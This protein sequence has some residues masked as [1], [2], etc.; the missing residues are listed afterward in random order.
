[1][2]QLIPTLQV[3]VVGLM[4]AFRLE[5]GAMFQ[6]MVGAWIACLGRRSIS[7]VWETTGQAETR[8]HTSAFRLFSQAAWNWDD[9][10]RLLLLQILATL[11]PGVRV[12]LVVDDTLC[13]KRGAKVAFGGIFLDAVLSTKRHKV[14]RFGNNWVMLGVVVE[15]PFRP[16]RYFCLPILWRVYE[17]RGTKTKKEHRTKS[18][19]A[20]EMVSRVAQWLPS[21]KLLVVADSAYIGKYLLRE[22]PANVEALGPIHW[23]AALHEAVQEPRRGCRHGKRLPTPKE[24][25]ANDKRYPAQS[26]D[27]AFKNG[28]TRKLEVKVI[29]GLCW[30]SVTGSAEVQ[31]VLVRDPK[32][33]WRD[34][35]LVCTDLTLTATEIITGYCRRWSVEVAFCDGKQMLGFHDPQVWCAKSV[36]RAAPMAWFTG[37]LVVLWYALSGKDGAAAQRHRPWYQN[38]P[39]PTFADML[40]AC[41]LQLWQHWL[42]SSTSAAN[43]QENLDWLL[44]YIATSA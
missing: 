30:Y 13:H 25:L 8:S 28:T 44:E 5:V 23:R 29:R 1:M 4:P 19:L 32:G 17:K 22:R 37:S 7:R 14:F 18:M 34:E 16:T 21:R 20:A 27:I 24:M 15:L 38:K 10:C 6:L 36:E 9:V 26:L 2:D 11:V 12:W 43:Y 42:E 39:T 31:L 3:V 41:R 40:S 35:A 33:E